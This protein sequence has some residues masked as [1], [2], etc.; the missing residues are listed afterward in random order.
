MHHVLPGTVSSRAPRW[1]LCKE[2]KHCQVKPCVL[3]RVGN[4]L[5]QAWLAQSERT[6][7]SPAPA[8]QQPQ[9]GPQQADAA[10]EQITTNA[11]GFQQ[12]TAWQVRPPAG[13]AWHDSRQQRCFRGLL[14]AAV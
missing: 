9:Q 8:V 10:A 4:I 12:V 6:T 7:L 2:Y 1:C 5:L 14:L 11:K 3:C 13:K